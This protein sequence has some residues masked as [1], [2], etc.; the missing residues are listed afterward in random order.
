MSGQ[1]E[2]EILKC[3][4][5]KSEWRTLISI[6]EEMQREERMHQFAQEQKELFFLERQDHGGA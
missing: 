6:F 5:R 4:V 3:V 1:T 2:N